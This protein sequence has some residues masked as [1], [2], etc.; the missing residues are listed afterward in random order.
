MH[1]VFAFEVRKRFRCGFVRITL[2]ISKYK[3]PIEIQM[4]ELRLLGDNVFLSSHSENITQ[5]F[6]FLIMEIIISKKIQCVYFH[7]T[8]V[9]I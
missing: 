4:N 9:E 2:T 8:S 7:T 1:F 3:A 6:L 5:R